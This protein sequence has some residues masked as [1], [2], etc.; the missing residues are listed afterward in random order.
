M[1]TDHLQHM[2]RLA[3]SWRNGQPQNRAT[4]GV[5]LIYQ[6]EVYGWKSSLRDPEHERPGAVAVDP[7]GNAYVAVGGNDQTGARAWVPG[8]CI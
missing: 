2:Q 8:T 5:A 4:S 1:T 3:A 6:Y 7:E